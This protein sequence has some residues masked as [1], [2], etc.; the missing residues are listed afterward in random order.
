MLVTWNSSKQSSRVSLGDLARDRHDGVGFRRRALGRELLA[1][2][3]QALLDLEHEL[4]E[5]HAAL[6]GHRR[7][8]EEQVHQHRLAAADRSPDVKPV[9][10]VG[11]LGRAHQAEARQQAG[12]RRMRRR[13]RQPVVDR[14]QAQDDLF[15]HRIGMDF[16][17]STAGGEVGGRSLADDRGAGGRGGTC[18]H[19]RRIPSSPAL[20]CL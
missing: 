6:L 4:V 19:C 18:I 13:G 10:P 2:A 7:V 3:M 15:L 14:L 5:V 16:A 20:G 11:R 8:G 17:R 9:R 1:A 12:L